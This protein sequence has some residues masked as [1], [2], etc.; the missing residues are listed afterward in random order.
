M[1]TRVVVE[2]AHGGREARALVADHA[3]QGDPDVVEV[4]SRVGLPLMPELLLGGAEADAFVRLL[5]DEGGDA[6]GP[7][8]GIGHGE[9]RVVLGDA[10]RW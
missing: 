7:G 5:D 4:D 9:D 10:G 6:P 2:G 1:V 8:C 3:V